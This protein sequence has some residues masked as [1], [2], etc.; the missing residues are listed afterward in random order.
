MTQ[1]YN[2]MFIYIAYDTYNELDIFDIFL[3]NVNRFEGA[4]VFY[5]FTTLI[6][7]EVVSEDCG[8]F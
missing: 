3:T 1:T 7:I 5:S 8:V 2:H 4:I 6:N